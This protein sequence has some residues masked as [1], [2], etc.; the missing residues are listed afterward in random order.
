MAYFFVASGL[1]LLAVTSFGA[2]ISWR[3]R[4]KECDPRSARGC[5]VYNAMAAV[6][7]LNVL[8]CSYVVYHYVT[9]AR[10]DIG[11]DLKYAMYQYFVDASSR[12]KLDNLHREF[13]C[14]GVNNYTDWTTAT[15]GAILIRYTHRSTKQSSLFLF[16]T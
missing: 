6:V 1:V 5:A 9:R 4:K 7:V 14:C 8:L 2:V 12:D 16:P 11:E 15:T 3:L 10:L 13:K